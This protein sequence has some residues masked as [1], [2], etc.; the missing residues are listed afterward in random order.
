[1]IVAADR[2]ECAHEFITH[3]GKRKLVWPF[4]RHC[5]T[6]KSSKA[7]PP[8]TKLEKPTRYKFVQDPSFAD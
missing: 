8:H 1:M 5:L 4:C 2:D 6:V 7:P 3:V